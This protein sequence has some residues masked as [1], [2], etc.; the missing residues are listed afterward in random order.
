MSYPDLEPL[1][2]D[3]G[4]EDETPSAGGGGTTSLNT[5]TPSDGGVEEWCYVCR[6]EGHSTKGCR[7]WQRSMKENIV[8]LNEGSTVANEFKWPP[9]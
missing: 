7:A 8:N 9:S 6:E 3:H 5:D 2:T 1:S 4:H